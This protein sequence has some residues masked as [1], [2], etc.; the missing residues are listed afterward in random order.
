MEKEFSFW[1]M[2]C[3]KSILNI[4]NDKITIK[5]KGFLAFCNYGFRGEKTIL[6]KQI[7]GIQLKEAKMTVGY[8]QFIVMG[9]QESKSGLRAAQKDENS[10]VFGGGFHDKEAN[11]NMK[12]IKEYIENFN[13][14]ITTNN[15]KIDD[16]YDKL[17][18]IKKLLDDGIITQEEFEIEK[19]K[20]LSTQ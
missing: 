11:E 14:S 1:S 20:L 15:V 10:I 3:G 12:Y 5:R 16:Q 2:Q 8:I 19:K 6:I 9:S 4:E 7:S 17:A 18:K 13:S